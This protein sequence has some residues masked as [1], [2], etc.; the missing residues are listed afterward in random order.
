[1]SW[2]DYIKKIKEDLSDYRMR[3]AQEKRE[4]R[5]QMERTR[6]MHDMTKLRLRE[7]EHRLKLMQRCKKFKVSEEKLKLIKEIASVKAE[8][9]QQHLRSHMFFMGSRETDFNTY[10]RRIRYTR[11]FVFVFILSLWFLLFWLGGLGTGLK[12]VIFVFALLNTFG[13][14][15]VLFFLTN[16]KERILKPVDNLKKGVSEITSGNYDITVSDESINEITSL[17]QAFNKM[18][19]N[20]RESE[21]LKSE[22]EENRKALIANISHDLKTP[23]TSIQGYVEAITGNPEIPGE[24]MDSYLKIIHSNA[25]YMNRLIDDLFLFSKLDMQKLDFHFE[26]TSIHGF[27]GD[28]MEE[29]GLELKEKGAAFDYE[30]KLTGEYHVKL[31]SKRFYQI[32]RNLVDNAVKYG[33]GLNLR[34]SVKLYEAD[35]FICLDIA[36]NGPGINAESLPHL[37]DRFYR[38]ESG[39]TKDLNST[40]LG[41]AIAKEL[42]LAHGGRISVSSTEKEGSCF[43]VALPYMEPASAMSEYQKGV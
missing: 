31:D 33:S 27:I 18:A 39:R 23:I 15:S 41:L 4:L 20:L 42:T 24:K 6:Y 22:Y 32:I 10:Y 2:K 8:Q 25:A 43:T 36:D 11:P 35:K 28:M 14:L 5:L 17:T 19:K 3:D 1:M 12:I 30:N 37:F 16:I 13:S 40:G 21:K 26:E 34:I 9:H 29:F 7:L 38:A